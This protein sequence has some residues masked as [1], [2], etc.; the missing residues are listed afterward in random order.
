EVISIA[1]RL[2]RDAY[3]AVGS[4][5]I[6]QLNEIRP[7]LCFLGC[8][9]LSIN[10]GLTDPDY[11]VVQVKQQMI[12]TAKKAAVLTISEKIGQVK[13]LTICGLSEVDYLFTELN[14]GHPRLTKYKT[15]LKVK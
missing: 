9:G 3:I 7:D 8:N 5:V 11:E 2:L 15:F 4:S 6:R 1:G 14:P 13:N 10:E 12:R